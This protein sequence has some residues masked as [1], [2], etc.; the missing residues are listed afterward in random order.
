[1]RANAIAAAML[2]ASAATVWFYLAQA[3][4]AL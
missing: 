3:F 2:A 4:T 1:M